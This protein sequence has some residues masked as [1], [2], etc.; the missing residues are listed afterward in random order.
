MKVLYLTSSDPCKELAYWLETQGENVSV[1]EKAVSLSVVKEFNPDFIVSYHY[2]Y[3]IPKDII[4][5]YYPRIINLH[6][7]FLPYNRGRQPNPWSF[8]ENTPKGVTIHLVDEKVD[9]GDILLQKEV[10]IDEETETLKS[11][12]LKLH[13]EIQEL[14]KSNWE[15]LK[16]GKIQPVKQKGKG[17]RKYKRDFVHLEPFIQ[18]KGWDTS[19]RDFKER[20]KISQNLRGNIE[21]G[22][23]RLK[24]FIHLNSEEREM[25]RQWRNY[26]EIRKWMYLAREINQEEHNQ[27]IEKL[28]DSPKDFCYLIYKEEEPI[29]VLCLNK[30]DFCHQNA[31][32]D[33]YPNPRMSVHDASVILEKSALELAFSIAKLHTLKLEVIES[34]QNAMSFCKRM[35]FQE[36][37]RLKEFVFKEGKWQDVIIMGI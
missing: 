30:V 33:V 15:I 37:G 28:V 3:I 36:E 23:V 1:F 16:L 5:F 31:Y 32:L 7:S 8:I 4:S 25:V 27:F 34:N 21:F 12:Y 9:T 24:N 14:F 18:E 17:T 6:L 35:G 13:R 10:F 2:Q 26:P 22:E 29:G 11:S 19:I 20:Y